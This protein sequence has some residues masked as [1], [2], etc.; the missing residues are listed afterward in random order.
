MPR[1]RPA[2]PARPAP[3]GALAALVGALLLAAPASDAQA[4]FG[5]LVKRAAAAAADAAGDRAAGAAGAPGADATRRA[6][7]NPGRLEI[8]AERLDAFVVAMRGPLEG[9]RRRQASAAARAAYEAAEADY[10]TKDDAYDACKDRVTAGAVPDMRSPAMQR[11]VARLTDLSPVLTQQQVAAQAAGDARGAALLADSLQALGLAVEEASF[12]ALRPQCGAAP[13]KP[14]KP[15]AAEDG[16]GPEYR[17]AVPA[18]M[19]PLQFGL[20]RE[21]V[22]AWLVAR[23]AGA[24]LADAEARALESRRAALE[25]MAPFF[26]DHLVEWRDLLGGMR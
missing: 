10:R 4:Q 6:D 20:L 22:G 18:G 9:A 19:T 26:R 23:G 8:T 24:G 3:T 12:P 5:R 2:R 16:I 13:R 1:P 25:P 11:A 7:A 21:R 17:P 14:V 15:A